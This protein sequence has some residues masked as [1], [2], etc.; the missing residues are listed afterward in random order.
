MRI[1]NNTVLREGSS[2]FQTG[3]NK[4]GYSALDSKKKQSDERKQ[5]ER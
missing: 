5:E 4:T 2:G 1:T 3:F